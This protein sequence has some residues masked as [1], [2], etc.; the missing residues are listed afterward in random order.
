MTA[1]SLEQ[2]T[3]LIALGREAPIPP[4]READALQWCERMYRDGSS[5]PP[6][7]PDRIA[8]LEQGQAAIDEAAPMAFRVLVDGLADH[9]QSKR[10]VAAA[11]IKRTLKMTFGG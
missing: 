5:E 2:R 8:T 6:K 9:R 4:E 3:A 1:L 11:G 10:R 7:V